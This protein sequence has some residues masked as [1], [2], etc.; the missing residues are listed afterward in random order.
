MRASLRR[1]R[2]PGAGYRAPGHGAD[3]RQPDRAA[4]LLPD[5]DQA[6]GHAGVAGGHLD[7]PDQE[8]EHE[9]RPQAGAEEQFRAEHPAGEGAVLGE[10]GGPE[11]PAGRDRAADNQQRPGPDPVNSLLR[12]RGRGQD[13]RDERQVGGGGLQRAVPPHALHEQGEEEEHAD[14]RGAGAQA[15]QVGPGPVPAAQHPEGLQR[16]SITPNATSSTAAAASDATTLASPQCDTPSGVVAALDSPYTSNATPAVA[17][18]APG[19]SNRPPR[20]PV[21]GSTRAASAATTSP[22]GTLTNITHRQLA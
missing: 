2:L 6:G 10:P 11:H 5:V 4:D 3:D 1:R 20:R 9:Q 17:V 16:T 15:D 12:D 22:I 8:D 18:R 19:R 14:Q 13:C 7:Q 21:S